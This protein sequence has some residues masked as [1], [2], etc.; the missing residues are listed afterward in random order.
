MKT[1]KYKDFIFFIYGTG[2]RVAG[3]LKKITSKG[4]N[5]PFKV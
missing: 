4:K 1:I 2:D 5:N 3:L